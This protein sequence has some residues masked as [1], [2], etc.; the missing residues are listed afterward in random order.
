MELT[1]P[2][3]QH[4]HFIGIGQNLLPDL[5]VA[6]HQL[7]HTVTGSDEVLPTR[8]LPAS[9][10]P[11]VT[12]WFPDKINAEVDGIIVGPG[13]SI[14]NPELIFG[15]QMG[16]PLYSFSGFIHHHA[17][18]QQ[19]IVVAG[20]HSKTMIAAILCHVLKVLKRPFDYVLTTDI[21]GL[22]QRIRLSNA[23]IMIIESQDLLASISNPIPMMH[24]FQHHVAVVPGIEWQP[25]ATYPT[26]D[27]YIRHYHEFAA[28]TPKGGAIIYFELDS[29]VAGLSP[30]NKVDVTYTP[31]KTHPSE[32]YQGKEFLALPDKRRLSVKITGK[33]NYQN[34]SAALEVLKRVGVTSEL[35]YNALGQFEGLHN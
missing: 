10:L 31:Y 3:Q 9:V 5:A 30:L 19:R 34:I 18:D 25:T 7:G 20:S 32:I 26:K 28:A 22:T 27:L 15:L 11:R 17:R 1:T 23:P 35:F 29:V 16:I 12:G 14:D 21:P 24:E 33:H 2:V 13:I 4:F 8:P 6:L